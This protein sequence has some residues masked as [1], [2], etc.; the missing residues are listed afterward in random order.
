MKVNVEFDCSP[1][2]ARHFL[3]LPDVTPVNEFYVDTLIK[4][5]KGTG[6]IEQIQEMI[7]QFTPMGELGMKMFQQMMETGTMAAF[8]KGNKPSN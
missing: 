2:E 7:K 4:S 6:N 5:M 1:A 8:G 3:G